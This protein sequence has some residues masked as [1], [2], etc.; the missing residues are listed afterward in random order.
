LESV[1]AK[2][3]ILSP[4]PRIPTLLYPQRAHTSF[5]L[6]GDR[7]T[8]LRSSDSLTRTMYLSDLIY[9][10]FQLSPHTPAILPRRCAHTGEPPPQFNSKAKAAA[11]SPRTLGVQAPRCVEASVGGRGEAALHVLDVL[12]HHRLGACAD[13]HGRAGL[14]PTHGAC[15]SLA[16]SWSAG[17]SCTRCPGSRRRQA[18]AVVWTSLGPLPRWVPGPTTRWAPRIT[19]LALH[20]T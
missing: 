19:R 12:W 7:P 8:L 1:S 16:R 11:P 20:G 14:I 13:P 9:L 17:L 18:A 4:H 15:S 2:N 5:P 10:S 3:E 6:G